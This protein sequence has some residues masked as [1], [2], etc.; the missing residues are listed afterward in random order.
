MK[1]LF[2]ARMEVKKVAEKNGVEV[3]SMKAVARDDGSKSPD[4]SNGNPSGKLT[5]SISNT[6]L[7]GLISKGDQFDIDFKP[8]A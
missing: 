3:I 4:F 7:T 1:A 5:V 8:V 2:V 6:G